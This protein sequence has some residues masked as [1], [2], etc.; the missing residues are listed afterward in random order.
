MDVAVVIAEF[1]D[2]L[3]AR[4][5]APATIDSYRGNIRHFKRYLASQ[6]LA[7]MKKVTAHV[8]SAYQQKIMCE[9]LAPESKALK[10]RVVKRLFEYLTD[11]HCLLINPAEGMVEIS[12]KHKKIGS[13]L[14]VAQVQKLLDQP[15][16]SLKSG[17]RDRAVMA[18]LYATGIRCQELLAL[19]VYHADL[20]EK[21]LYIRK[22]KARKQ[23][24]VPLGK[25]A[26]ESLKQYLHHVRPYYA[27]RNRQERA[28]FL[29]HSG[30]ALSGGNIRQFIRQYRLGAGIQK[31][32]SPH[33]F[34]R[35]C[36]THLLQQGAD[37][38]YIQQLLGHVHLKTTQT[39][40][41]IMPKEVKK[42]HERTHPQL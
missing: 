28:L 29:N 2:Q 19:K 38:R 16:V 20:R 31:S 7:D 33:T 4:G 21:V 1:I 26:A 9:A 14:T 27:R 12:R 34:R 3:K 13:I 40:T 24:V 41:K 32:V 30:D 39:Y 11:T 25:Q 17:I 6:G 42:T 5:Y 22:T 35:T 10:I 8:V 18:V 37:I 23:R 36:A 15:N